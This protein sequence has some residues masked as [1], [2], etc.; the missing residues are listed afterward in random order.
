MTRLR[1]TSIDRNINHDAEKG[2]SWF[3]SMVDCVRGGESLSTS[4]AEEMMELVVRS[5]LPGELI[6]SYLRALADKGEDVGELVGSA[7]CLRR[8]AAPFTAKGESIDNCGTGGD[9]AGTFNISTVAA[10]VVAAVGQPVVK[11]GNRSASGHVGSADLLEAL[12]VAVDLARAA[13]Q[14]SLD[15]YNFTFLF[16]PQYHPAAK[17]VA[18]IRR[19]IGRPT[20]FNLIGPLCNP[21]QPE[22]Q[23]LGVPNADAAEKVAHA[24]L[25]LGVRRAFIVTGPGGV[26]ELIPSGSNCVLVI[27]GG[28]IR[29]TVFSACEAG[30]AECSLESLRGGDVERNAAIAVEVLNGTAG[31]ARDAVVFNAGAALF[32]TGMAESLASGCAKCANAIDQGLA[33]TLL[34]D[35]RTFGRQA[36]RAK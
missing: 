34:G 24:I 31:G 32:C 7:R 35:L 30:M 27:E 36:E 11:H 10:L 9:G 23:L 28:L 1:Q 19:T 5:P 14:E 8:H 18:A 20:I 6:E 26:D 15:R 16:A 29:R 13:A 17:S 25:Q 33:R 4:Q 22:Y 3:S 2:V 21:A 12:G